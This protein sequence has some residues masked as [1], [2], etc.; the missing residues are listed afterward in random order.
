MWTHRVIVETPTAAVTDDG[1]QRTVL[2]HRPAAAAFNALL[3]SETP[4]CFEGNAQAFLCF[5]AARL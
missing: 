1:Q 3:C 5:V 4:P 2:L